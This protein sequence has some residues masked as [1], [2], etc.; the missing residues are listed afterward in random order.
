VLECACA[1]AVKWQAIIPHPVQVAVNVSSIQFSRDQFVDEVVE[2]LERVGL[3]PGLLQLELTESVMLSGIQRTRGTM[4]RLKDLGISLAI[5]DF[6]TGY[7]CLSYLPNL[8]FDALKIDR[9]FIREMDTRPESAALVLSL[10]TLAKNVGMRV[11][12]EGIETPEQLK[13]IKGFGGD[14]IQGYLMGRPTPNPQA[15][16]S[17][18]CE[19]RA[20]GSAA[21]QLV[22][23]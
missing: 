13:A 11:I 17:S 5:D 20:V 22:E 1:E 6:G 3:K 23:G 7:S 4:K 10:V 21:L 18:L 16:I 2:M 9:S 19:S 8:P 15:V 14:E 12:V